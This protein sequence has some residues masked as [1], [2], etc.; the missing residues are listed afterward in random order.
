MV[1]LTKAVRR[2]STGRTRERGKE[3]D[4]VVILRPP[5]VIGFRA[6][7]CRKEYPLT[8]DACY[9]MAVKAHVAAEKKQTAQA[10]RKKRK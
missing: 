6:K 10:K 7:G 5:N 8:T 4:V 9:S 2:I 1:Y 3:R